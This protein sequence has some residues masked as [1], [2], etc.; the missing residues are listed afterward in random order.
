MSTAHP[1][2]DGALAR[3]RQARPYR[4]EGI[5][6]RV[7]GLAVESEGP[8]TSIGEECHLL[9]ADGRVLSR[10]QVV[11]FSGNRTVPIYRVFFWIPQPSCLNVS[12]MEL[13][14]RIFAWA[15]S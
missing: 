9:G 3:V 12:P 5:V 10:A 8:P 4:A 2:L 1:D 14:A 6:R 11:G 13:P 15:S 7:V